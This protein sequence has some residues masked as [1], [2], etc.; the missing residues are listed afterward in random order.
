VCECAEGHTGERCEIALDVSCAI[1]NTTSVTWSPAMD[2]ANGQ[3]AWPRS[4]THACECDLMHVG[5]ACQEDIYLR[6]EDLCP[7]PNGTYPMLVD[8]AKVDVAWEPD[9]VSEALCATSVSLNIRHTPDECPYE[10]CVFSEVDTPRRGYVLGVLSGSVYL[11]GGA[12]TGGY[13]DGYGNELP[14]AISYPYS[15]PGYY[16]QDVGLSDRLDR[17]DLLTGRW[18]PLASMPHKLSAAAGAFVSGK[19]YVAGGYDPARGGTGTNYNGFTADLFEY[20]PENDAWTPKRS[21]PTARYM[22]AA[23]E[24]GG[25]LYVIGG[26]AGTWDRLRMMEAYDPA[27]NTWTTLAPMLT[28]RQD[29]T[30][31]VLNGVIYVAGG[32]RHNQH[33]L[34]THEA[35]TIATNSW[36]TR[37]S[38]PLDTHSSSYVV[39]RDTAYLFGGTLDGN[40]GTAVFA[41]DAGANTWTSSPYKMPAELAGR[42]MQAGRYHDV[43]VTVTVGN[44]GETK[45]YLVAFDPLGVRDFQVEEKGVTLEWSVAGPQHDLVQ[46]CVLDGAPMRDAYPGA[47]CTSPLALTGLGRG[48]HVLE[49]VATSRFGEVSHANTTWLTS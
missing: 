24:H 48:E 6:M 1:E 12:T 44:L 35:Y 18:T 10:W 32:H 20:D 37:A 25:L 13:H 39:L 14:G 8:G 16:V 33:Q 28:D 42:Y 36:A 26:C 3:R 46:E 49:V 40:R 7:L 5:E 21:M 11:A 2:D 22:A 30:A 34:T 38:L 27:T 17:Y 45:S 47:N 9:V 23:V 41:Y 4:W 43:G 19:L 29:A 31:A 15:F